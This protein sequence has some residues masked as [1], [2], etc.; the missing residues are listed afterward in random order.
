[1]AEQTGGKERG[2]DV[3]ASSR[4]VIRDSGRDYVTRLELAQSQ[5]ELKAEITEKVDAVDE[6]VDTL[7]NI[8]ISLGESSRQTAAN[9]ERMVQSLDKFTDEQRK[10]NGKVY[11]RLHEHD[12]SLS[13]LGH[14]SATQI[15]IKKINGKITAAVIAAVAGII[16]AIFNLAPLIFN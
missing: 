14:E 3:L 13:E 1:M 7:N 8:V 9:T 16:V 10:T 5:Y 11:D 2:Q 12:L 15:E 4:D 6:K